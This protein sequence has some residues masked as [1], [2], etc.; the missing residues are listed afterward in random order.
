MAED[1]RWWWMASPCLEAPQLAVHTMRTAG[2]LTTRPAVED[3]AKVTRARGRKEA[4]YVELVDRHARA[5]LVVLGVEV[6]GRFS[7]ENTF[8]AEGLSRRGP[9]GG[10][11]LLAR[12]AARS[13]MPHF[14]ARVAAVSVT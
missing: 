10:S 4:T 12:T 6:G 5:R 7:G 11:S 9:S 3:G 14:W 13:R 1:L 2:L 8:S